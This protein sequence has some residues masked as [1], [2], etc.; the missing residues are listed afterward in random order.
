MTINEIS[1]IFPIFLQAIDEDS[2]DND[3]LLTSQE[4]LLV[5]IFKHVCSLLYLFLAQSF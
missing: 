3:D 2:M 1:F 4:H 5:N